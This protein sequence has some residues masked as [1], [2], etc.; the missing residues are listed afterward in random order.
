MHN[1]LTWN[2]TERIEYYEKTENYEWKIWD[3][4]FQKDTKIE[5]KLSLWT[6]IKIHQS[7]EMLLNQNFEEF[8]KCDLRG[9]K[10]TQVPE[11][12]LNPWPLCLNA[13]YQ[14]CKIRNKKHC[15]LSLCKNAKDRLQYIPQQIL[16]LLTD[17][18]I[19]IAI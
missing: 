12:S 6:Y 17:S 11:S 5:Q 15:F 8:A 4:T 10:E 3:L 2:F 14:P 7:Q 1:I 16:I 18:V 13:R 19:F 9:C